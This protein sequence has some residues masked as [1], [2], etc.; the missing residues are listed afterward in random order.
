MR[1]FAI[2]MSV[3]LFSLSAAAATPVTMDFETLRV[4]SDQGSIIHGTSYV[5]DGFVLSITC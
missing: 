1:L 5:E 2:L 3:A 4:E